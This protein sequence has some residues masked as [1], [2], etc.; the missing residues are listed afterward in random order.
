[1]ASSAVGGQRSLNVGAVR[2]KVTDA[3]NFQTFSERRR[4]PIF[5]VNLAG[6]SAGMGIV[7]DG[8]WRI[9][10]GGWGGAPEGKVRGGHLGGFSP[11]ERL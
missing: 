7:A 6:C 2:R 10:S 9:P 4:P 11:I 3:S 1:M 8:F 5:L